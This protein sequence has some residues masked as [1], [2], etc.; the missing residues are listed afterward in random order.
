[1][2]EEVEM[3]DEGL[4]EGGWGEMGGGEDG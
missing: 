1:V 4:L 3:E 2:A